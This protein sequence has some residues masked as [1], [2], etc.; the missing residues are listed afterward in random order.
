MTRDNAIEDKRMALVAF[1]LL[2]KQVMLKRRKGSGKTPDYAGFLQKGCLNAGSVFCVFV[3][4]YI[5]R[6]KTRRPEDSFLGD[7]VSTL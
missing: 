2:G 1:K 4:R 5:R 3:F 7:G 6:Q